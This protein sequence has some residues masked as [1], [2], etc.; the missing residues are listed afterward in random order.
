V[1]PAEQVRSLEQQVRGAES[2]LSLVDGTIRDM[3]L[4]LAGMRERIKSADAARDKIAGAEANIDRLNSVISDYSLLAKACSNDGIVAL[5]LDDAAP[6]I[7]VIVND[8]L[9]ACYGARFSVRLDTQAQKA[10]GS[11]REAFDIIV[12]DSETDEERSISD[13]SGGQLSWLEDA[14]TRGICLFNIHRS[15]RVFATLFSDEK[16][17]ALDPQRKLEF[18]AVKRRALELGT[19]DQEFFISHTPDLVE[20][21]DARIVLARGG[22]SIQ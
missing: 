8:L 9:R 3:E 14:I 12:Y 1:D 6:S 5:E 16:D 11:M 2:M 20:Q 15:D 13:T 18:L 17:G 22:V 19:H 10:D 7:A 4:R 21:A